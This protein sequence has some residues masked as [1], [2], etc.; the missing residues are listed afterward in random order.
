MKPQKQTRLSTPENP[1]NGNC[2]TAALASVLEIDLKDMPDLQ[3]ENW[4]DPFFK[5]IEDHGFEFDG[6]GYMKR[7]GIE[8]LKTY[9][10]VDGYVVVNGTSLRGFARGHSVVYYH[11]KLA[12][13]PHP[14]G[15]GLGEIWD[16]LMIRRKLC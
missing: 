11:G 8:N 3:G 5:L 15:Q 9:E 2:F 16:W 14:S 12:F 6:T 1:N 13:D 7:D 10:G 4:H